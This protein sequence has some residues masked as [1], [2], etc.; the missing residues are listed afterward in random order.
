MLH[1]RCV[2]HQAEWEWIPMADGTEMA[3]TN[4]PVSTLLE[5]LVQN[6]F[7]QHWTCCRKEKDDHITEE[8]CCWGLDVAGCAADTLSNT[9]FPIFLFSSII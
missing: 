1:K 9:P 5:T 7:R 4:S 6:T 2:L 8:L 3:V